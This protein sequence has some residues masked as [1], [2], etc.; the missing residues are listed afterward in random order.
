MFVK[1]IKIRHEPT[2]LLFGSLVERL[3]IYPFVSDFL[4]LSY[5]LILKKATT[6][7]KKAKKK[8]RVVSKRTEFI[9]T[10]SVYYKLSSRCLILMQ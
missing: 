1:S 10:V 9:M 6:K 2:R 5:C 7:K 4:L 3:N 8:K